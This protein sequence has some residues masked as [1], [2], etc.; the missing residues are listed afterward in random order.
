EPDAEV[1]GRAHALRQRAA[2]IMEL[3]PQ[4]PE[5]MVTAFQAVEGAS[6]LADFIAGMMDITVE[7]KQQ[8]LETFDLK[9]RLDRILERL[10]HRIEAL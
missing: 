8:L 10:S 3:L 5:E 7:E 4:V 6:Q 2:E 1:E 9:T